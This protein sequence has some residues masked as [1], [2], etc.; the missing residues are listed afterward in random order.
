M[1]N[2]YER[3]C[4]YYVA[5]GLTY[6]GRLTMFGNTGQQA[7]QTQ[8]GTSTG[9]FGTEQG[10]PLDAKDRSLMED[11]SLAAISVSTKL[12]D[13]WVDMPRLWFAQFEAVM[14]PQKQ[15]DQSKFNMVVSK[16]GRDALQQV[17]DLLT[18]PP[19][20][21]KYV[22]LKERLLQAYEESAERQFQKLVS[23]IELGSQKPT[24][25]LRR[26][27]N[28]GR[29]TQV[30]DQTLKSLWL[31]RM[32][33]SVRAVIAVCQDQS[34]ENLATIADKIVENTRAS[35][36]VA[37]ISREDV[38]ASPQATLTELITQ[39]G[40]LAVEVA[41]L[42]TEV[43]GRERSRSRSQSYRG[44]SSSRNKKSPGDPGWLCRFHYRYKKNARR[45]EQPCAWRQDT[46][47]EN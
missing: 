32:P 37:Q 33:A 36:E 3:N 8:Q 11:M 1:N 31:S 41:S 9:T 44:R 29:T 15:G 23:E 26:M 28:L 35:Y 6:T 2:F 24:Q 13:F 40:K 10:V 5:C 21:D 4:T 27:K 25:L 22:V 39:M 34:L 7:G 20:G 19:Q 12:P 14:A 16:L 18:S 45:C 42:R 38:A 30:S 43:R 47:T 17:S 46:T